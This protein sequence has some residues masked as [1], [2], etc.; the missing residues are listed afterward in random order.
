MFVRHLLFVRPLVSLCVLA[1]AAVASASVVVSPSELKLEGNY[2]RAQLLVTE[3]ASDGKIDGTS[4][5]LT[6]AATYTVKSGGEFVQ[7]DKQGRLLAKANGEAAIAVEAKGESREVK[8]TVSGIE[9]E[10]K[11]SFNDH[12]LPILSKAGCNAGACHASQYG[13][14]GFKLSVYSFDPSA[15]W[16]NIIRDERGRRVNMVD[17]AQS[18]FLKKPT[19]AVPHGGN[20]R[21]NADSVDFQILCDWLRADAPRPVAEPA[22]VTKIEVRPPQRVGKEGLTQQIQVI[23]TYSNGKVADVT[24]WAKYDSMDDSVVSVAADGHSK[25]VGKGQ[26]AVMVRFEGQA[27]VM[28]MVVPYS[29]SIT[30]AGWKDQNFID[31]HAATK[32]RELG[33][34]PSPL[35]DDATFLRRTYFDAIGTI[36]TVEEARAFLD[37]TDP[38]KRAK[39][40]DQLL[41]LTGDPKL[42]VHNNDYAAYWSVKWSDLIR[43]S[44]LN[45]GEQGMWAMHNWV[46]ESLRVNKPFDVFVKDLITATGSIYKNGPANYY[47]IAG[48]PTDLAETTAQ[49][50][51]GVRL[52]CAKCHHHP[53]EKYGQDDYYGFAACFARVG[54]KRSVEFG[55]FGGEQIVMVKTSGDIS[56]PKTRKLMPPTPLEGAPIDDPLDRR[57]ALANW[58]TTKDNQFFAKAVVNRYVAYLLGRGLVEPV[59]DMRATNPATNAALFDALAKDF[60]ASGFNLKHLIRTIMNSRLYQLDSQ[61]TQANAGDVRFYSHY[62]VKHLPAEPLLDAIDYATGTQT[63]FKNLPL[64]TKAIELP[65]AE[66]PEYF[67]KVFGKP[68]REMVCE[69]ERSSDAN[70]AQALHTLNGDLLANKIAGDGSRVNKLIKEKKSHD[71]IVDELYLATVSRHPSDDEKAACQKFVA[72][73][74]DPKTVY[75]DLLWALMN[76]KQFLHVR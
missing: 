39:L 15:D 5:D 59:D 13:K 41:G 65:D 18:L 70:L 52:Q 53:F 7:V 44:T 16:T 69:C 26:G 2:A 72:D 1:A 27:S 71:E 12:V 64:G 23:A 62:G 47:R 55:L 24:H 74:P 75:E 43:S 73:N 50:F 17:P 32:F 38:D 68:R 3:A 31:G 19:L 61:P 58:M 45:L 29:D 49:L 4:P 76:S 11:P 35:C 25:A 40:V 22:T 37:S 46:K 57:R 28:M 60:V 10:P 48:N 34:E 51:L 9:A 30:L 63:K 36:P 54:T 6:H 20:R 42:D 8:V 21:L 33:I 56:N 14:G 67:L 66:Y